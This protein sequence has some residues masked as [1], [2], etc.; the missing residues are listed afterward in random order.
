MSWGD[1]LAGF[2]G[3]GGAGLWSMGGGFS[4]EE[5]N[6]GQAPPASPS[7][8]PTSGAPG[9]ASATDKPKP[10]GFEDIPGF[11][12]ATMAP[13]ITQGGKTAQGRIT[14]YQGMEVSEWGDL[15]D[16]QINKLK[17][18]LYR[19]G[20]YGKKLPRMNGVTS[21]ADVDALKELMADANMAGMDYN[22]YLAEAGKDPE[23]VAALKGGGA[24][25]RLTAAERRAQYATAVTDLRGFAHDNGVAL[26][27]D[28]VKRKAKQVAEGKVSSDELRNQL[29][30]RFVARAY[31]GLKDDLKAGLSVRDVAAPYISS[32]AQLLEV[33]EEQVDLNDPLMKQALQ[34]VNDKGEPAYTPLWKF[35]QQVKQDKRWQYTDNAWN[36]VGAKAF[37][38]MKMFGMQA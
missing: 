31:P 26:P 7:L 1:W 2:S 6:K 34:G 13:S 27:N 17:K 4:D 14:Y 22:T 25:G 30:D 28:F 33:P 36:D 8:D 16:K 32:Y 9:A 37:E 10:L 12:P 38:V 21:K 5:E 3:F 19:G 29:V 35:E 18:S 20:Y 23:A 11:D 24:E 15:G